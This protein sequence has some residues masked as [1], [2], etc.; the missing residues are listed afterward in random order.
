MITRLSNNANEKQ[1]GY[2]S[3]NPRN[4][5]FIAEFFPAQFMPL[6]L[7]IATDNVSAINDFSLLYH[8]I[9]TSK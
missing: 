1:K 5:Y 4:D 9:I 7:S 3:G 2:L 6:L 8:H